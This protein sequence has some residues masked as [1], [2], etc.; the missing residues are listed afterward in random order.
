MCRVVVIKPG[1]EPVEEVRYVKRPEGA[2]LVML[3][4]YVDGYVTP[5]PAVWE[6]RV[7]RAYVDE[8]GEPRKLTVNVRASALVARERMRAAMDVVLG[9]M[10]IDLG[11]PLDG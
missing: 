10:V 1:D 8:D 3:Q 6:G 11:V 4:H 9:P 2:P 5:I 7:Y